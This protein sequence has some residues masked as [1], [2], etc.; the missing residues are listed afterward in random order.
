MKKI[1]KHMIASKATHKLGDLSRALDVEGM[2]MENLCRVTK[3]SET[4]YYGMWITGM[5]FFDV[6]FPKETTRELTQ[7]EIDF[8][9]TKRVRINNQ[10]SM[11]LKVD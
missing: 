7:E 4:D 9:N 1:D 8:F 11:P 2:Y 10:P 6:K 5:G 3:E